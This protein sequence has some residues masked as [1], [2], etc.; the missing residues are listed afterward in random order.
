[1]DALGLFIVISAT[2]VLLATVRV[3]DRMLDELRYEAEELRD[4]LDMSAQINGL[5]VDAN[6][7]LTIKVEQYE[8][9]ASLGRHP[10][11]RFDVIDGGA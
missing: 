2:V 9:A 1:M 11:R 10:S 8:L 4:E 6:R 5:L 7:E 3:Y